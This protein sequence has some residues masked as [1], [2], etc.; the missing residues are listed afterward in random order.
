MIFEKLNIFVLNLPFNLSVFLLEN[1]KLHLWFLINFS[2]N[3][4]WYVMSKGLIMR[5]NYLDSVF[6]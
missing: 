6:I 4:E 2:S 3:V 5:S 1:S